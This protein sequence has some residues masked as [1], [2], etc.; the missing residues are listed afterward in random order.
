M[1]YVPH[2]CLHTCAQIGEAGDLV[3]PEKQMRDVMFSY[4][5]SYW[6]TNQPGDVDLPF[7]CFTPIQTDVYAVFFEHNDV[8][9]ELKNYFVDDHRTV[10]A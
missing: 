2:K 1:V 3:W 6:S 10:W 4:P 9:I 8:T 7:F 5:L